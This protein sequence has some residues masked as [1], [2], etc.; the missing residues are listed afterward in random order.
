[1][2]SLFSV[3]QE[4]PS[5]ITTLS[6]ISTCFSLQNLQMSLSMPYSLLGQDH[7]SCQNISVKKKNA[8]QHNLIGSDN[9]S[10]P[11]FSLSDY[12]VNRNK[13]SLLQVNGTYRLKPF[14]FFPGEVKY[15]L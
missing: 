7:S 3:M 9:N 13:S 2:I 12:T 1:M 10:N 14:A 8:C 11:L 5:I 4:K 6:P 15:P